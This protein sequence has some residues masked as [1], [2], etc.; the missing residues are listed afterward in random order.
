MLKLISHPRITF[1]TSA[2][3]YMFTPLINTVISPK[4]TAARVRDDSPKRSLR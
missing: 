3:E 2:M 4:L 1:S